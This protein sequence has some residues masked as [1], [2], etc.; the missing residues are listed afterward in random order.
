MEC[1]QL[2]RL[3]KTLTYLLYII[4]SINNVSTQ[5]HFPLMDILEIF[6]ITLSNLP[7]WNEVSRET[8]AAISE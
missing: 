6:D 2:S 1:I 7:A 3:P 4:C 8:K 5:N